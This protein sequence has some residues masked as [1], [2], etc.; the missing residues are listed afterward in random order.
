[1]TIT[2]FARYSEKG[3]SGTYIH[4]VS[5]SDRIRLKAC[6]I[7]HNECLTVMLTHY[8]WLLDENLLLALL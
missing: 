4:G 5:N 2:R 8:Q 3:N 1:M 6:P 7:G